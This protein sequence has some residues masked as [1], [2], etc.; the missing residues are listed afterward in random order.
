MK[1]SQFYGSVKCN[2]MRDSKTQR[3]PKHLHFEHSSYML[4][5]SMELGEVVDSDEEEDDQ[6]SPELNNSMRQSMNRSSRRASSRRLVME[7]LEE[8][9]E[10]K[11]VPGPSENG[12]HGSD[13]SK[14]RKKAVASWIVLLLCFGVAFVVTIGL[15]TGLSNKEDS[16]MK[17][18]DVDNT[19]SSNPGS[20]I[21]ATPPPLPSESSNTSP[22]NSTQGEM[23]LYPP[24]GEDLDA[25]V[26][27]L[28]REDPS[29]PQ[30]KA[31]VWM[32][33]DPYRESYPPWK[34]LQRFSLALR[35][36]GFDGDNW[37]R[38]D[39]WMNYDIDECRWF[40]KNPENAT[41]PVC[42]DDD[43]HLLV[44]NLTANNLNG[45]SPQGIHV[46]SLRMLDLSHNGIH[47]PQAVANGGG[48]MEVYILSNNSMTG[49]SRTKAGAQFSKLRVL[50]MDGNNFNFDLKL[51]GSIFPALEVLNLTGNSF[52]PTIHPLFGQNTN[53]RYLGLGHNF[54]GGTLPTE[55]G[56]LTALEELDLSGNVGLTGLVPESFGSLVNLT[57]V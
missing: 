32:M 23:V 13:Y 14:E 34:Q 46:P 22:G 43:G 41:Y 18:T 4:T 56:L 27:R 55:L 3:L 35:Y 38:N 25:D 9:L 33:E 51:P 54:F 24:F 29:S 26:L 8:A 30:Y 16:T 40:N 44:L 10:V 52:G 28:I 36:I 31:N 50:K 48:D 2:T 5:P 42:D 17:P 15:A 37:F 20:S 57:K 1:I 49:A 11:P 21:T 53:L 45:T 6:E 39:N 19:S 12:G 7:D 47:G